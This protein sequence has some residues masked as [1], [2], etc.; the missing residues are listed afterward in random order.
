[1]FR[2]VDHYDPEFLTGSKIF[3]ISATSPQ[4]SLRQ[5]P[6]FGFPEMKT[7][8]CFGGRGGFILNLQKK[9][10]YPDV[11]IIFYLVLILNPLKI[12]VFQR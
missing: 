11:E 8:I 6:C 7:L 1:M 3:D 10:G 2:V 9:I 12:L 4:H 5:I